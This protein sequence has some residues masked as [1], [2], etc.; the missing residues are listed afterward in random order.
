[1]NIID[2]ID[3]FLNEDNI[4]NKEILP[5]LKQE[6]FKLKNIK[7]TERTQQQK[8]RMKTIRNQINKAKMLNKSPKYTKS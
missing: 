5:E 4:S 2:K 6:L 3:Y 1:M 7:R 8:D